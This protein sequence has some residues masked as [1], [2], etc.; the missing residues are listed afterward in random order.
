M[1]LWNRNLQ[2]LTCILNTYQQEKHMHR[3]ASLWECLSL[4]QVV[5]SESSKKKWYNNIFTPLHALPSVC[6]VEWPTWTQNWMPLK[7]QKGL[8]REFNHSSSRF[9]TNEYIFCLTRFMGYIGNKRIHIRSCCYLVNDCV[10]FRWNGHIEFRMLDTSTFWIGLYTFFGLLGVFSY[11]DR[12][13][14]TY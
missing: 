5:T 11:F 8:H 3:I 1:N 2:Y 9:P 7:S 6:H 14:R 4:I 12:Q 10:S 13:R